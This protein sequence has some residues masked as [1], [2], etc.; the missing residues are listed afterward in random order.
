[1]EK[2]YV[3]VHHV[4]L[5]KG[6]KMAFEDMPGDL[7]GSYPIPFGKYK[8]TPLNE[9]DEDYIIFLRDKFEGLNRF[10]IIKRYIEEFFSPTYGCDDHDDD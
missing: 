1:M 4:I 6:N 3:A 2:L 10:P 7:E 8:G 5:R 9:L